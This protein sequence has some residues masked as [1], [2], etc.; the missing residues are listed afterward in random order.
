MRGRVSDLVAPLRYRDFRLLWFAQVLSE[1]GDWAGRLALA[2][3]VAEKTHSTF[4]TAL[5]T[6]ASVLPYLGIGQLA[7]SYA[8]RFPRYRV[9]L[10]TD[11]GRAA[12][13]L[14]LT[15]DMPVGLMLA[16]A[17][18]AG[19]LTPPF[20]SARGALTP[21]TVPRERFGDAIALASIT[22][23]ASLIFGFG[24]AGVLIALVGARSALAVN[25]CSFIA[26]AAL[27]VRIP[28]A[29]RTP[30]GGEDFRVRDAMRVSLDDPFIR[31]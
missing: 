3:I 13:F 14:A 8:N 11:I 5:V 31:R 24:T 1:V 21:L 29:R 22:F 10:V 27:L 4:L 26:S 2:V 25:A 12:L 18:A 9:I 30:V 15:V 7:A 19:C 23:D 17:F 6:T 20:E 28:A 16:I